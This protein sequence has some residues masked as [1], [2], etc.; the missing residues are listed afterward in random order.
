[1]PTSISGFR[2]NRWPQQHYLPQEPAIR[3]IGSGTKRSGP[4]AGN[5]SSTTSMAPGT[6]SSP[7]ATKNTAPRRARRARPTITPWARAMRCSTSSGN[8]TLM[9]R[10]RGNQE[11]AWTGSGPGGEG[12]VTGG[13]YRLGSSV[14]SGHPGVSTSKREIVKMHPGGCQNKT[15]GSPGRFASISERSAVLLEDAV[16]V[17]HVVDDLPV[18]RTGRT[19]ASFPPLQPVDIAA[20]VHVAGFELGDVNSDHANAVEPD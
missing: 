11:H 2:Q 1:M 13:S 19:R 14:P 8:R 10:R 3:S 18:R 9:S 7:A 4:T 5:T 6:A 12:A 16:E 20:R 17:R 15:A